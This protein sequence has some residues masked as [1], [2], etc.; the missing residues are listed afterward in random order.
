MIFGFYVPTVCI[1]VYG[2][3]SNSTIL[4]D[5]AMQTRLLTVF[6]IVPSSNI[7]SLVILVLYFQLIIILYLDEWQ[8][9]KNFALV[10]WAADGETM[11]GGWI[12]FH[13]LKS[14]K[15][16]VRNYD[17]CQETLTRSKIK[18]IYAVGQYSG[19]SHVLIM[20][21]L[22]VATAI[23]HSRHDICQYPLGIWQ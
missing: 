19:K 4:V 21:R 15:S 7:Y 16:R 3:I 20:Q 22:V 10:H 9:Q 17:F 6:L 18:A 23:E 12:R 13:S 11:L 5:L 2:N 1:S 14:T 8:I